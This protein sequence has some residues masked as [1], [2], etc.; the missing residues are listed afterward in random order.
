MNLMRH[1]AIGSPPLGP[2]D[3]ADCRVRRLR[4]PGAPVY[5]HEE[6]VVPADAYRGAVE[7]GDALAD[8]VSDIMAGDPES[9]LHTWV[10]RWHEAA[11]PGGR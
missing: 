4:N 3:T 5:K 10:R 6:V 11:H 1:W 7:A 9:V 8:A 2:D